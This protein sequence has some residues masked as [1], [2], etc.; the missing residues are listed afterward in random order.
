[1]LKFN[2]MHLTVAFCVMNTIPIF[3]YSLYSDLEANLSLP[4]TLNLV[5]HKLFF[6][7]GMRH[8]SFQ[9]A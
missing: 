4:S 6:L 9:F 1:M 2:F 7:L 5:K 8:I 3:A